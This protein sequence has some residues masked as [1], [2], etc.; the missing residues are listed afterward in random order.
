[1]NQHQE[2]ALIPAVLASAA[3]TILMIP[4]ASLLELSAQ[5]SH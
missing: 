1:M 5:I 4:D 3:E 2:M